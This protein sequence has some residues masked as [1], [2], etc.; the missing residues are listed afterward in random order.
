MNQ[1]YMKEKPVFPLILTM[2]L[3]MVLSMLVNALY[4]IVDSYFVAQ[5]NE[6]AMTA[7]S[8]VFPLQ[9]LVTAV[10]VGF[11]IG[12]NAAV[13][14]YLGAQRRE[15]ACRCASQGTLLNTIHGLI[16]TLGCIAFMP[17]FLRMFTS[18][19]TVITYGLDYSGVVFL[20]SAVITVGVSFE[21]LFQAVGMMKVSM[22]SMLAGCVIN[23][24]L[25]PLFIFGA[26]FIPAMG[27]KGAA[28]AT[29]I[30]Q[31]ATLA[32]YLVIY[33]RADMPVRIRLER[34]ALLSGK[35][36]RRLY[37]VGI[38]ATLNLALSSLLITAL[39][40][41]LSGFSQMYVLILGI[42]YKL[43]TFIYLTANGIV[44]GIRPLVSYNYG[45]GEMDRVKKIHR[46]SLLLGAL[47][48]ALG[49]ALCLAVPG[50][51]MGL[52]TQNPQTIQAGALALRII[53]CGFIISTMS[54]MTSG[55]FEGLGKGLPSLAISLIRYIA[56]IPIA[57]ILSRM[58]GAVGVWHAFWVTEAVAAGVSLLLYILIL[59]KSSRYSLPLKQ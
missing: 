40:S 38:P 31:T 47:I 58:F 39:N 50:R 3:P 27:V 37:G 32:V 57:F 10:G 17:V 9:N 15:D 36:C 42:Y 24:I 33:L 22:I 44:Q 28:L 11:G 53:S 6:E 4:N 41:I 59:G 13:A 35:I 19:E 52:F 43:Q 14:F 49:T 34:G 2:S 8:L 16:L 25:D 45:A 48:M 30:G 56:I 54:V 1:T 29:G 5:I 18:D 46:L 20:F 23:I 21:K 12:I 7:L 51:I 26:G 55:T